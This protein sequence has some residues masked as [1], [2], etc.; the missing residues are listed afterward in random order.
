MSQF[1]IN[2]SAMAEEVEEKLKVLSLT[3]VEYQEG[4]NL[5]KLFAIFSLL[6]LVIVIMFI[7][8][9]LLRRDLHT[10]TYGVGVGVI[11]N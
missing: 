11:I 3:H 4:D 9:F 7:T 5:G 10:Y 8:A 2:I 6:P 1:Q